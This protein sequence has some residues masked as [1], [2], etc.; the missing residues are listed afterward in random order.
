MRVAPCWLQQLHAVQSH[1]PIMPIGPLWD[2]SSP[3]DIDMIIN[4]II[5]VT[6]AV[7]II[8]FFTKDLPG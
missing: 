2:Y 3:D 6:I 7:I 8:P 4:I 1:V 5:V